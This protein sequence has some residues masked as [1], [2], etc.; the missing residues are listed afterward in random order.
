M[1]RRLLSLPGSSAGNRLASVC[2]VS[3]VSHTRH[4]IVVRGKQ[5]TKPLP[6]P[7][8][9][10][11]NMSSISS[12]IYDPQ[13]LT[14]FERSLSGVRSDC[15]I[16]AY[17]YRVTLAQSTMQFQLPPINWIQSIVK[18]GIS[19]INLIGIKSYFELQAHH[20]GRLRGK[21]TGHEGPNILEQVIARRCGGEHADIG[22]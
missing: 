16:I 14:P 21:W 13:P 18:H 17:W 15:Q 2:P 12:Q 11:R 5:P 10:D 4:R 20:Q 1:V 9:T 7:I 8:H 19:C 3:K 22:C 6:L